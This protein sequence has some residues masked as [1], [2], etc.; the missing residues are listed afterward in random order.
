MI[1][2]ESNNMSQSPEA[3]TLRGRKV[4]QNVNSRIFIIVLIIALIPILNF[5][6]ELTGSHIKRKGYIIY[7]DVYG[8]FFQ[9]CDTLKNDGFLY[10]LNKNSFRLVVGTDGFNNSLENF[11][12]ESDM[13][14]DT[15]LYWIDNERKEYVGEFK[16]K[17]VELTF[18]N[19]HHEETRNLCPC[20][21]S[22]A[23]MKQPNQRYPLFCFT[24]NVGVVSITNSE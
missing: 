6:K 9:P 4:E 20:K 2:N 14:S 17:F 7:N 22:V 18:F 24:F 19:T 8:C 10:A 21:L 1:W 15:L 13:R 12:Q 3:V 23:S 11:L 5:G 16:Y